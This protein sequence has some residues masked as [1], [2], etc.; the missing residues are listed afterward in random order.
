MAKK[1]KAKS[2]TKKKNTKNNNLMM[3]VFVVLFLL[4]VISIAVILTL[5]NANPNLNDEFFVSDGSKYVVAADIDNYGDD[6]INAK[7]D[8]KEGRAT[9]NIFTVVNDVDDE[10]VPRY[11][12]AIQF[13]IN[14]APKPVDISNPKVDLDSPIIADVVDYEEKVEKV[15]APEDNSSG[16]DFKLNY[17]GVDN[18]NKK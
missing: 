9:S 2:K 1:A 5:N 15:I 7:V 13:N 3:W 14:L 18:Y 4:I 6:F 17:Q 11:V 12:N 16:L 8:I 10:G